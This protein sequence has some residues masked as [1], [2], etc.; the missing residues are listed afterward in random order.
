MKVTMVV[1]KKKEL[2]DDERIFCDYLIGG[3]STVDAARK[4]GLFQDVPEEKFASKARSLRGS[5]RVRDYLQSNGNTV[6]LITERD[7]EL[8]RAHM[9]DIALGKAKAL[10]NVV[11]KDGIEQVEDTPS[12]R[13]QI[14]A[15]SFLRADLN[16]RKNEVM[17]N[18]T[19]AI[20][21]H[22]R[23]IKDMSDKFLSGFTY[24]GMKTSGNGKGRLINLANK[25]DADD[26]ISFDTEE[27]G[28]KLE[29]ALDSEFGDY[30]VQ[31]K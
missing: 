20:V 22:Y 2:S 29:E 9:F 31:G 13:D 17:Q 16:D 12:F 8:V 28:K 15:A 23:E 14:A 11:T 5:E 30:T 3:C 1:Q 7:L 27:E 10:R 21:A 19:D 4:A 25:A 24:R 6:R 18:G 26:V